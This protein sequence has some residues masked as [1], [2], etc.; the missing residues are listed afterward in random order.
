MK[1]RFCWWNER[2]HWYKVKSEQIRNRIFKFEKT[3]SKHLKNTFFH[4]EKY[5]ARKSLNN[6]SFYTISFDLSRKKWQK[7]NKHISMK[8]TVGSHFIT[9]NSLIKLSKKKDKMLT[10]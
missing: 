9:S 7:S 6:A 1:G 2:I 5:F 4:L 10:I 3:L 8:Q